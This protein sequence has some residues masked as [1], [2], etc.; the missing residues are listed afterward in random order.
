MITGFL[1]VTNFC[2]NRESKIEKVMFIPLKFKYLFRIELKELS[3][4]RICFQNFTEGHMRLPRLIRLNQ[5]NA[6]K[7]SKKSV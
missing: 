3:I 6:G 5:E 7:F 2:L 1:K 4:S